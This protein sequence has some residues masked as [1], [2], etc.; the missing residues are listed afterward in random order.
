MSLAISNNLEAICRTISAVNTSIFNTYERLDES[1]K[2][3]Q[4]IYN[5]M[6]NLKH[7]HRILINIADQISVDDDLEDDC[8]E[9]EK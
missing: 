9:E 7:I 1:S 5:A 6:Q 2:D 3:K 4:I 8:E